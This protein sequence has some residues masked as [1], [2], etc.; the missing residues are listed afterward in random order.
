MCNNRTELDVQN[1][2]QTPIFHPQ[3][4]REKILV[5]LK[6]VFYYCHPYVEL[7]TNTSRARLGYK[8]LFKNS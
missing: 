7:F 3:H 1:Q 8:K 2:L 6:R 4:V 5:F